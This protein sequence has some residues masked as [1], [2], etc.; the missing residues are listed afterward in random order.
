MIL[1]QFARSLGMEDREIREQIGIS[2]YLNT[3][4]TRYIADLAADEWEDLPQ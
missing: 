2:A 4:L 1:I 3:Q